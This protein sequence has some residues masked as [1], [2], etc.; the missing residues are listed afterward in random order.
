[1]ARTDIFRKADSSKP[2]SVA[3]DWAQ[4]LAGQ[5]AESGALALLYCATAP[6]LDGKGG[7]Y[8][9]PMYVVSWNFVVQAWLIRLL[10][11]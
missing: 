1:M 2:A 5:S 4:Y 3:T 10:H 9:G 7:T 6:E 11:V 8:Y